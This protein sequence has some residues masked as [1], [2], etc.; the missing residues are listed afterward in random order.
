LCGAVFKSFKVD[1]IYQ[2]VSNEK[3]RVS[4]EDWLF[5][6]LSQLWESDERYLCVSEC[7]HFEYF[8][9]DRFQEFVP[10]ILPELNR[11]T[12]DRISL[13]LNVSASHIRFSVEAP[14]HPV[15]TLTMSPHHTVVDLKHALTRRTGVPPPSQQLKM[16]RTE[17]QD[18]RLLSDC[19]LTN[20]SV[21][22][23]NSGTPT[24]M[25]NHKG[26]VVTVPVW[27]GATVK[28]LKE[29]LESLTSVAQARQVLIH[30]GKF[31]PDDR[32]LSDVGVQPDLTIELKAQ[33]SKTDGAPPPKRTGVLF[34]DNE[35]A[36]RRTRGLFV[37][38]LRFPIHQ[39]NRTASSH[40]MV[41]HYWDWRSQLSFRPTPNLTR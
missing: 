14:D 7:V 34:D 24:I 16:L 26:N 2:I 33:Q 31:L 40:R 22:S 28:D 11:P 15:V 19:A 17:L 18:D 29:V 5:T 39:M 35:P 37:T 9:T 25:V 6:K 32:Q 20:G 27:M 36:P 38:T 10:R 4:S 23:L 13:P 21:I 8:S 41:A 12:W 3:F 1:Q 30:A